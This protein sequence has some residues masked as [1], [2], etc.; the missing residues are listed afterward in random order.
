M[1]NGPNADFDASFYE[2]LQTYVRMCTYCHVR[3]MSHTYEW[4]SIPNI[5]WVWGP[6][7]YKCTSVITPVG[8]RVHLGKDSTR[9]TQAD[10]TSSEYPNTCNVSQ[11]PPDIQD[12]IK[13]AKEVRKG[14]ETTSD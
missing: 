8:Q 11:L 12:L 6:C 2:G 1:E 9:I 13:R 10:G 4:N 3:I 5:Q 7:E 14:T